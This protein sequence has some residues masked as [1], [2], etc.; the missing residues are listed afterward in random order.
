MLLEFCPHGN[1][2]D[3]LIRHRQDFYSSVIN[4]IAV[5]NLDERLFFKWAHDIAKG[6]EYL[7][8]KKIMHGDL[9]ARN[10]LIGGMEG[11]PNDNYVAKISDFGL[12]K[13]FYDNYR[14]KKTNREEVPW[15]WMAFEYLN[16]GQFS[17]KS[18]VW[19]YG[20]VIWE[21]LSLGQEPY[22]GKNFESI[23]KDFKSGFRLSCPQ[24]LR[25]L[26][27]LEEFYS[28]VTTKCWETEPKYRYNFTDL[29]RILEKY[30]TPSELKQNQD[31]NEQYKT[32][33]ALIMNDETR[34]KRIST[35]PAIPSSNNTPYTKVGSVSG[36]E[37]FREIDAQNIA[38]PDGYVALAIGGKN[39]AIADNSMT[40]DGNGSYITI[41]VPNSESVNSEQTET[42]N[43]ADDSSTTNLNPALNGSYITDLTAMS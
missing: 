27:W 36:A 28:K 31:L 32:M 30:L 19:S 6:M 1:L 10:I 3:F 39:P 33:R 4:N 38:R 34:L 5:N 7:Y 22:A 37:N 2:K 16:D 42:N 21:I 23:K 20:V 35:I 15:K 13:N 8:K 25:Q 11:D 12:S 24:E 9:A 18:D 29:V 40:V 17:M 41:A 14:Y 26:S 43:D